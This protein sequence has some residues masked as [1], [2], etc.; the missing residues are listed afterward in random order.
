VVA[1]RAA[2]AAARPVLAEA[3][4]AWVALPTEFPPKRSATT[5]APAVCRPEQ[6]AWL[7]VELAVACRPERAVSR[8]P[9]A[10]AAES[11]RAAAY[12]PELAVSRRPAVSAEESE[13]A[14]QEPAVARRFG[15]QPEESPEELVAE[16]RFAEA[17]EP[18]WVASKQR[19]HPEPRSSAVAAA[20]A[21]C[22]PE[23]AAWAAAARESVDSAVSRSA[24]GQVQEAEP[25]A[26]EDA[27]ASTRPSLRAQRSSV[28]AVS[29][30]VA[31]PV[32]WEVRRSVE[33]EPAA[34]AAA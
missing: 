5:L 29:A 11:E 19:S 12:T 4:S 1:A 13:R 31:E 16:P 21:V 15:E 17:E 9:A 26:R 2:E 23:P 7:A 6:A 22:R 24:A 27:E 28:A 25:G 8:R 32:E 14:A 3:H 33:R 18:L 34:F 20:L 30:A 10:S